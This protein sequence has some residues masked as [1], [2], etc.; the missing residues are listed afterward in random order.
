[1]RTAPITYV[2]DD[3]RDVRASIVF[4]LHAEG[5]EGRAFASGV[6]FLDAIP[7]LEPGCVLMDV[8]MPGM[9]G[10]DVLKALERRNIDWPVVMMTGH[11]EAEI[12]RQA[13]T[14]GAS[15]FIEKPFADDL[16]IECLDKSCA[17][18]G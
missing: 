12:A 7:Q 13:L 2:I 5:R 14:L 9:S 8:R 16:L 6:E 10:L 17:R 1:M 15:D 18:S 11:G 4:M 3:D